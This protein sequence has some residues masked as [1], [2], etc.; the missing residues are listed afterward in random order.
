L[1][2][3]VKKKVFYTVFSL[4]GNIDLL[5]GKKHNWY[6]SLHLWVGICKGSCC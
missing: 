4:R 3:G 1:I 2:S 5:E 6:E